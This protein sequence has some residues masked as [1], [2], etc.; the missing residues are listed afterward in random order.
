MLFKQS[1]RFA[2]PLLVGLVLAS[3][4]CGSG[5]GHSGSH[6]WSTR[7]SAAEARSQHQNEVVLVEG[8][9]VRKNGVTRICDALIGSTQPSCGGA[10]LVVTPHRVGCA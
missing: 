5:V 7:A 3:G 4:G 2:R 9:Y 1:P 6:C 8:H 10:G